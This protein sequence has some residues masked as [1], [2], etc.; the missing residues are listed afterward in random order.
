MVGVANVTTFP[1]APAQLRGHSSRAAR[2]A[3]LSPL[4]FPKEECVGNRSLGNQHY[5]PKAMMA[6]VLVVVGIA[7]ALSAAMIP[8]SAISDPACWLPD[9]HASCG[10]VV[11]RTHAPALASPKPAPHMDPLR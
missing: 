3:R 4:I 5:H 8:P 6:S 11:A 1:S 7:L 9:V 2:R 10:S